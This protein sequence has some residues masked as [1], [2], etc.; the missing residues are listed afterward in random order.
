[1]NKVLEVRVLSSWS[2]DK[3]NDE[4]NRIMPE[5]QPRGEIQVSRGQE[6]PSYTMMMVRYENRRHKETQR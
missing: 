1:M 5:F 2:P 3:L 4:I 6:G